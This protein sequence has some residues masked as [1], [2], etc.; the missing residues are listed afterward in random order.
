MAVEVRILRMTFSIIALC[1]SSEP[2]S[3]STLAVEFAELPQNK[4]TI[5]GMM[6]WRWD[7]SVFLRRP[8]HR[9][10]SPAP[11]R[12]AECSFYGAET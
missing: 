11:A 10:T 4:T 5:R 6:S 1:R 7:G 9:Y 2:L 3:F 12:L 8:S